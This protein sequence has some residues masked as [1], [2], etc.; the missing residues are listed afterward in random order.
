MRVLCKVMVMELENKDSQSKNTGEGVP[1][2][3]G[4]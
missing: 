3:F 2:K 1:R 4:D